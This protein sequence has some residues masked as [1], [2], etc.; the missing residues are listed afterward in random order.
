[1]KKIGKSILKD[2]A[3]KLHNKREAEVFKKVV[4][5]PGNRESFYVGVG[6]GGKPDGWN[7]RAFQILVKKGIIKSYKKERSYGS[8]SIIYFP[9][10][11]DV[12][13]FFRVLDQLETSILTRHQKEKKAIHIN[14][15]KN[16]YK[17][18]IYN[19]NVLKS[20]SRVELQKLESIIKDTTNIRYLEEGSI[21]IRPRVNSHVLDIF[22][23]M[24][25]PET[26]GDGRSLRLPNR[27]VMSVS[28]NLEPHENLKTVK[29]TYEYDVKID[30]K[31]LHDVGTITYNIHLD[32]DPFRQKIIEAIE[33]LT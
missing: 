6:R 12:K 22:I 20:W 32:Y 26:G 1:M 3:P 2:S 17:L 31:T 30:P 28:G 18:T 7:K 9:S 15:L 13:E 29:A 10:T 25:V 19:E 27:G 16:R 23:E 14:N 8:P 21:L 5:S 24:I 4:D 33:K 11:T